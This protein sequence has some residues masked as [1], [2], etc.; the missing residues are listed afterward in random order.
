MQS[1]PSAAARTEVQ[2][3]SC[4]A[5]LCQ[6]HVRGKGWRDSTV[7]KD[8]CR[9]AWPPEFY[10]RSPVVGKERTTPTSPFQPVHGCMEYMDEWNN[11]LYKEKKKRGEISRGG[12]QEKPS[13]LLWSK[14]TWRKELRPSEALF[15]CHAI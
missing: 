11:V 15:G 1:Q 4:T 10:P 5:L 2:A 14:E 12:E 6:S 9:Q 8:T 7:G 13:V 3:V